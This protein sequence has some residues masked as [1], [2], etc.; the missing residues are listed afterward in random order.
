M[1]QADFDPAIA[2]EFASQSA[3]IDFLGIP[4]FDGP[5]LWNLLIRFSKQHPLKLDYRGFSYISSTIA[6]ATAATTISPS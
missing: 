1:L 5:N 4:L 3:G 6:K 2:K